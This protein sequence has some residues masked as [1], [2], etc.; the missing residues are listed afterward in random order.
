M[1]TGD[2]V[3]R[4]INTASGLIAT[5]GNTDAATTIALPFYEGIVVDVI[6]DHMHPWYSES[7]GFNV[8]TIKVRIPSIDNGKTDDLLS[9]ATPF[10]STILE[11]PLLGEMVLIQ[12]IV[13][14]FYYSRKLYLVRKIQENSTLNINDLLNNRLT[15]LSKSI[16]STSKE[17]QP[18]QPVLGKYFKPDSRIRQLKPFEGD[19]LFQGRMG[20]SIRFGSSK[21]DPGSKGMAPNIILRTGQ[22]KDLEKDYTTK[23]GQFGLTLED[24]NKDVSS[25]WMVS[26]QTVPFEPTTINAGS[27]Y[28]SIGQPV[29]KFDKAQILIN[30]DRIILNSKKT[31]IM[32]FSNE[33]IYL[34]GFRGVSIDTDSSIT[35]TAN[36]DINHMTSRNMNIG[37]DQ[38][39][40]IKAGS[41]VTVLAA[42][43][44]SLVG[45]KIHIGGIQNDA[46]PV[47]GGT[48]LS[49]FLARLIQALMGLGITPPQV[50]TYQS[51]GSAV[52]TTS[53]PP[54]IVPGPSAVVH[55]MT[56][57]G[58]GWLNPPIVTALTALYNELVTP[59][60]GSSTLIPF[61]GAPFS[62]NDSFVSM[63]N[64][65]STSAIIPNEF[66]SGEQVQSENNN[67]LLDEP[68]Y[69]VT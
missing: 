66:E 12:K 36:L 40:N 28:R 19:V 48:S 67:W 23:D 42:E 46:E 6:L 29:Q 9:W 53:T 54:A 2:K 59:N 31:H 30:S 68:Y 24:I 11:L 38:D 44:I 16:T 39:V 34:N 26:D 37:V 13:G 61:S 51:L 14:E 22:G 27:F 25:I 60:P 20:H 65:D 17:I 63:V 32:L 49:I 5:S 33:E 52:P 56:S 47:V 3:R 43:K 69:K 41:D 35:L 62:S 1:H 10:D 57:V 64:Q 15:K 45:K 55:V 50:P 58:P 7:D 18:S 4:R 8:G 21:M